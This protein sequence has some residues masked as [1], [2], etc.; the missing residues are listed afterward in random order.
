MGV[1][2]REPIAEADLEGSTKLNAPSFQRQDLSQ[3][4]D[5]LDK[6]LKSVLEKD[7]FRELHVWQVYLA[8]DDQGSLALQVCRASFPA[9]SPQGRQFVP[10][11]QAACASV[12]PLTRAFWGST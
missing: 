9:A 10:Q 8:D 5:A 12:P 4:E 11:A 1:H 2:G 3:A 7:T 6:K